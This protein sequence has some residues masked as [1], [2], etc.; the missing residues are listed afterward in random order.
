MIPALLLSWLA[1]QG[2]P[3][4]AAQ[5]LRQG[6]DARKQGQLD[7]AIVEFQKATALDPNLS[8]AFVNL[9][10]TYMEKHDY[11]A[12]IAP[13]KRALELKPDL[14]PAHQLLGYALLAQGYAAEAIPHLERAGEKGA[15]GIAEIDAG[16]LP[17]AVAHLNAA[18]AE[19]PNDLDLLYYLGRASGL[20][21]KQAID[22]L[23]AAYPDSARGHQA[24]A[25]NYLVLRRLPEAEKE[26]QEALR[27]RP[28][29][30]RLHLE[31]GQ[32][33][34]TASQWTKAEQEFRAE[35]KMQ[36]GNAEAAYRLG[37]ALLEEGKTHEA[38][39]ELRS[40][41]RLRPDMPETL[42]S[43]GKA[44]LLD[45]DPASAVKAWKK[46]IELEGQ[47]SLAA[48]AHFELAN[49]YR[50]QGDK[51]NAQHEIQEYQKLQD[52]IPKTQNPPG[53]S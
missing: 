7:A 15:L 17:E 30:P 24:M 32:V 20:L 29:T 34:A 46:V 42:Y 9:G 4:E 48:Q 13:L 43:L 33:Y 8:E 27:L 44:A 49:L 52:L 39:V 37:A 11:G 2:A 25:E 31:L 23:Q 14:E 26:Y 22:T 5:H 51:A 6:L 35:T 21:S 1:L 28:E 41:D 18:L 16:Q 45:G 19:R 47:S 53:K 50:K 12:A 40:A 38:L 10:E 36:P 3:A